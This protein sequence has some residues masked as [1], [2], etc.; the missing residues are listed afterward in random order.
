M[1]K[2]FCDTDRCLACK[3]CEL[4]CAVQHSQSKDLVSAVR[5]TPLPRYRVKVLKTGKDSSLPLQ[6]RHC[7]TPSCI[8][9]CMTGCL[10]KDPETGATM[11]N[12]EVCVG[13]WMCVMACPYGVIRPHL[14][15]AKALKCDLCDG[16]EGGPA[17]VE[18]CPTKAL[19]FTEAEEA[20]GEPA[21]VRSAKKK[22]GKKSRYVII[23]N[24]AAGVNAA[25]AIRTRD[26]NG[27]IVIY[28]DEKDRV[29]S[30]PL[31]SYFLAGKVE[32]DRMYYRDEDF[33]DR[34]GITTHLGVR[35]D[36]IDFK[37]GEILAG[38]KREKYD[39]LLIA[40]GA[41]P[42][43]VGIPGEEADGVFF[44]RTWDDVRGMLACFKRTKRAVVL[45][46][47][48]ISLKAAAG[49]H[50][51]G[52]EL[53]LVVRSSTVLSQMLD[54]DAGDIFRR[55]VESNGIPVRTGADAAEILVKKGKVAGVRLSDG[56]T[57]ACQMVVIGKG[58]RPD[59]TLVEGTRL[60]G[61][62]AI[63]ADPLLR[64]DIENVYAAGDIALTRDLS[65]ERPEVHTLWPCA[66]MQ[67]RIA[68][69]N[70]AGDGLTYPGAI[71]K[72]SVEFFGLPVISMGILRTPKDAKDYEGFAE[73]TRVG[74]DGR[75]YRKIV[76]AND[77]VVGMIFVGT[78]ENAG[79]VRA[80]IR[81]GAPVGEL[82]Q[83]ILEKGFSYAD[84]AD[85][86]EEQHALF[87]LPEHREFAGKPP[88][89]KAKPRPRVLVVDDD[90]VV[91]R[92]CERVLEHGYEV[93][94]AET[95]RDG[96]NS[97]GT[98]SFDVAL[99]DLKL[100]DIDGMDILRQASSR[101][102]RVP[103]IIITGYSTVRSAVE[104]IKLGAFEYI[105]KPFTPDELETAVAACCG[106]KAGAA[107][108]AQE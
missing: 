9:A 61:E 44:M 68:G 42:S 56:S 105:P 64:T 34:F 74:S 84:I 20:V 73:F 80:L 23:G 15:T 53:D 82:R 8:D 106:T 10:R 67:G 57:I 98:E 35:V 33:Y 104:A 81:S 103:I 36:E 5:E 41:K 93:Q 2:I 22:S 38:G 29:Y 101:F 26:Q 7:E 4:A 94:L 6:C 49:L 13:C 107:G 3:S 32:E 79:V 62:R 25:E 87:D 21:K 45:G 65:T 51:R 50:A 77:R 17:C 16:R 27:E 46:G 102:P 11:T 19:R 100:P 30:R 99:V 85:L 47:G 54:H 83:R 60:A 78:I 70:M 95:G 59:L 66:V 48:L 90:P 1:K 92:S 28:S 97:L 37:K 108:S 31:I 71:W 58:A 14:E 72:N 52:I 91:R 39:R 43:G 18:A 40:A 96:L 63:P 12:P 24:S 76:M 69:A 75:T 88:V 55:L 89:S 86:V